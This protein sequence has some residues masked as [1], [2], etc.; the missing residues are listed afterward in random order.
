[1]SSIFC[2]IS[3]FVKFNNFEIKFINISSLNFGRY[4][5]NFLH[6]YTFFKEDDLQNVKLS[7]R[8]IFKT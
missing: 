5:L 2:F 4:E 1:M 8:L 6:E 3:V 7:K